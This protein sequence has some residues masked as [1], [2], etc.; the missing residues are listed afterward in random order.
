MGHVDSVSITV[1]GMGNGGVDDPSSFDP[2][3][4]RESTGGFVSD[5]AGIILDEAAGG[6]FG[7]WTRKDDYK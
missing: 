5:S 1:V 7:S 3:P 6:Q 4:D 2:C